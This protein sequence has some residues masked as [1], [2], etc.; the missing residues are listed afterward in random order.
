MALWNWHDRTADAADM[1]I[2]AGI[3][4]DQS[5]KIPVRSDAATTAAG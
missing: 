2:P 4:I 3:S 5:K 1:P